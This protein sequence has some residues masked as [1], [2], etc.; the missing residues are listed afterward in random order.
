MKKT[1]EEYQKLYSDFENNMKVRRLSL[2]QWT[3]IPSNPL[4]RDE[5]RHGKYAVKHHLDE[6]VGGHIV[7]HAACLPNGMYFKLDGHTRNY[8][9]NANILPPPTNVVCIVYPAQNMDEVDSVV[10]KPPLYL[11]ISAPTL[12]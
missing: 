2:K 10:W 6:A 9:W 4:Q 12:R 11:S 3:A 7:V 8:L 1:E 5:I